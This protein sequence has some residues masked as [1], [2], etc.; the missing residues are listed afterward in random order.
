[1]NRREFLFGAA[2]SGAVAASGAEAPAKAAANDAKPKPADKAPPPEKLIASAPVLQNAA[3]TSIGVAFAVTADA[4]GWVEYSTSPDMKNSVRAY[5][6]GHGLMEVDGRIARIRIRGLKPA[7]K[8][9]YRIGADR[10]QFNDGYSMHNLGPELDAKVHSFTTLGEAAGGSFCVI[11][12]THDRK[13]ILD[14][15]LSKLEELKPS[16][17]LWN[18]DASNTSETIDTAL[19]IFVHTHEKHPEY[20]SDTPYMFLN[21]NHDFRGR[22]NRSLDRLMMFRE[23]AERKP[24]YEELGRNFVQRLGDIALI[25]LDTGEDKLDTNKKF[26]GIFRMKEYREL[27]TKWL[28]D[29]IETPAIKTAKF[30]VAFCHIPLEDSRPGANPGD[31]A[32]DDTAPGF[33]NNWASWQRTCAKLWGPLFEKAGV[34]LAICAHQHCVRYSPPA[35]GRSWAQLVGGGCDVV[36]GNERY[37]PSVIQGQ[38]VD[39]KLKITVYDAAHNRVTFEKFFS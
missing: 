36:P 20:A 23:A 6:G 19:G 37:Y 12:D 7:T 14:M 28:A 38:V 34:Q 24:E 32:P 22:F 29:A 30:K 31:L 21:G 33:R 3:D 10:I 9:Y 4:S 16:V 1:M 26:A 5:S 15:V 11:N 39:G 25:G 17:V 13:P 18:G 27:Q 2:A 35:P 8:Y